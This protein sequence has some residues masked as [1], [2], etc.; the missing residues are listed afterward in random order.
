MT[1]LD[2]PNRASLN[3]VGALVEPWGYGLQATR[4]GP[5]DAPARPD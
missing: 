4:P 2:A 3:P 5:T 1:S